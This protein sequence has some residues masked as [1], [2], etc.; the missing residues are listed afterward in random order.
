MG[1]AGGCRNND[2]WLDNPAAK[3]TL[4]EGGGG[5]VMMLQ[6]GEGGDGA[7]P[8]RVGLGM[9]VLER[10]GSRGWRSTHVCSDPFIVGK[11][12]CTA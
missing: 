9:Y 2:S 11:Q 3:I 4:P 8:R 12:V 10:G 6:L 7:E 1:A 5:A